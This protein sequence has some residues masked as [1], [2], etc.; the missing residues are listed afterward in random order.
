MLNVILF[1]CF[2]A[3]GV[4]RHSL[5]ILVLIE[6][7][8]D[9]HGDIDCGTLMPMIVMQNDMIRLA[10]DIVTRLLNSLLQ[11]E[12]L[13]LVGAAVV[14]LTLA[15]CGS[16][17][18]GMDAELKAQSVGS[19]RHVIAPVA[20]LLL[21][22]VVERHDAHHA[23]LLA[24]RVDVVAA[25]HRLARILDARDEVDDV[26]LLLILALTTLCLISNALVV[27][28]I[29]PVIIMHLNLH[30]WSRRVLDH[31]ALAYAY[32]TVDVEP[33][34]A[35]DG[36]IVR[37]WIVLTAR[38]SH[39]ADDG[40]LAVVSRLAVQAGHGVR[41]LAHAH[42]QVAERIPIIKERYRL[43]LG[44]VEKAY[45]EIAVKHMLD[46]SAPCAGRILETA[47]RG[48]LVAHGDNLLAIA[49]EDDD[50]NR[51]GI[52]LDVGCL[53]QENLLKGV[54]QAEVEDFLVRHVALG[55]AVNEAHA[56]AVA[57]NDV[58]LLALCR[59][60]VAHQLLAHTVGQ[61]VVDTPLHI[62]VGLALDYD[63]AHGLHA[64][65]VLIIEDGARVYTI[66]GVDGVDGRRIVDT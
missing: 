31:I 12:E 15:R 64:R 41:L 28:D 63:V 52:E 53:L 7:G 39:T 37:H 33:G 8:E 42:K 55:L 14:H 9:Y 40:K 56:L 26:A 2:I 24:V 54:A 22:C 36:V 44:L 4:G 62:L 29:I 34:V 10:H 11:G 6:S 27:A 19:L 32:E 21:A 50:S 60:H 25:D 17:K 61:L 66:F 58:E 18:V 51:E 3:V 49:R 59:D 5:G 35:E 1:L 65:R 48:I 47:I 38:R 57:A 16:N 13:A 30:T 43:Y 45:A 20:T 46:A 23:V